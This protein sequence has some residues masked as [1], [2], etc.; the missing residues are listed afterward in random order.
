M[1]AGGYRTVVFGEAFARRNPL[2]V[3]DIVL[4]HPDLSSG[5]KVL[6][7]L[8]ISYARQ[9]GFSRAVQQ[10]LA[11]DTRHTVRQ[12][13]RLLKELR[14]AGL[15]DWKQLGLNRP[16]VYLLLPSLRADGGD[17]SVGSGSDPYVITKT[18]DV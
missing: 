11:R 1:S 15:I 17:K 6:F 9:E 14:T 8:L 4:K 7:G 2:E 18:N 5:A 13:Q 3:L 16:N 10:Q 12:V